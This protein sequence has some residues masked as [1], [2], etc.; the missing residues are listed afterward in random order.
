MH[1]STSPQSCIVNALRVP[2][3]IRLFGDLV[4]RFAVFFYMIDSSMADGV[5]QPSSRIAAVT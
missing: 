1:A 3:W 4:F 5:K 2:H